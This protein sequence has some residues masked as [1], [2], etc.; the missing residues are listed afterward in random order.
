MGKQH[1]TDDVG[2]AWGRML[3]AAG[4]RKTKG[5]TVASRSAAEKPPVLP[6]D[7]RRL[8][9]TGRTQQLNMKVKPEYRTELETLAA[10]RDIGLAEMSERILAEWKALGGKGAKRA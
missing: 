9:A 10:E 8:R 7:G 6:T 3:A 4:G 2:A 5:A 1:S